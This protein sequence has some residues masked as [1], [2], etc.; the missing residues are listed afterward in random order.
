MGIGLPANHRAA[1]LNYAVDVPIEALLDSD[2]YKTR[3][4]KG[5]DEFYGR[6][7]LLYHYLQMSGTRPGQLTK[8]RAALANGATEWDAAQTAFGDLK[9]LDKELKAY[10]NKGKMR[11]LPIAADKLAVGP[12]TIRKLSEAESAMM[13]IILESKRGVD[14]ESAKVLLPKAQA[15]AA[16]YPDDPA[17]LAALAEAEHDAGNYTE[18]LAAAD[19]ALIAA[20]Q[21]VATRKASELA[22]EAITPVMP[23]LVMGS[24]D[25][26]PSN[27]TRTKAAQ[28]FTPKTPKGRY[29]R[30]GI[31]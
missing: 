12:I 19:K 9:V 27:N 30:Y 7:W 5:Y 29:V 13:P 24:A 20:P 3:K 6:S 4:V 10:L 8:Y 23:E 1:E 11:Y 17:V 18:A 22:L 15:V 2:T 31:R 28:D 21:T 26:T 14:E 25:L 16:K